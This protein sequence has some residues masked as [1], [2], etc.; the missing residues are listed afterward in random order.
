[1]KKSYQNNK[2]ERIIDLSLG[3]AVGLLAV[4]FLEGLFWGY[5]IRKI[6]H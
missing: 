1:M 3:T 4:I 6:R 2:D 5:M